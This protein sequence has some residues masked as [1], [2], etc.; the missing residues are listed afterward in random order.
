MG[1]KLIS[2]A[3]SCFRVLVVF[4]GLV[5]IIHSVGFRLQQACKAYGLL[6]GRQHGYY[7]CANV[8]VLKEA[9]YIC[10]QRI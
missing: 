4:F 2:V 1:V 10:F 9:I 5:S 3:L 7:I 6:V 8:V